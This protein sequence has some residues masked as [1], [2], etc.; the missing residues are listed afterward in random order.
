MRCRWSHQ[1]SL[2]PT[3]IRQHR[4]RACRQLAGILNSSGL[5]V[6]CSRSSRISS[7]QLVPLSGSGPWLRAKSRSGRH[8]R[9][10][11]SSPSITLRL[12]AHRGRGVVASAMSL[13]PAC[14]PAREAVRWTARSMLQMTRLTALPHRTSACSCLRSSCGSCTPA[15]RGNTPWW[16]QQSH[17]WVCCLPVPSMSQS[18]SVALKT[19]RVCVHA[20]PALGVWTRRGG[21]LV[22][23]FTKSCCAFGTPMRVW[24]MR[25]NT[26]VVVHTTQQRRYS[27]GLRRCGGCV[28]GHVFAWTAVTQSAAAGC[29]VLP[30]GLGKCHHWYVGDQ[31]VA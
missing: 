7:G 30:I 6:L 21:G 28:R 18:P 26:R 25:T 12:R 4:C 8:Q 16:P 19:H 29:W 31:I 14:A 1:T 11:R 10:S 5:W 17:C 23:L 24:F 20:S 2:P 27:C 15:D 9:R 3:K 22:P 13:F